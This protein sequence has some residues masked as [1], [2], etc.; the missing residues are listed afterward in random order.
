MSFRV[1]ILHCADNSY[2]TGHTGN[3]ERRIGEHQS[4]LSDSC[5]SGRLPVELVFS[6]EC[7]TRIEALSAE[8]QI[9]G[10]SRKKKEAMIRGDCA[11]VSRSAKSSDRDGAP[12]HPSTSSGRTG[13]GHS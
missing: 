13:N 1:Y 12:V 2:Y 10:W 8:R 4:G 7:S 9:R 5:T 11:E 6:Q 3:L